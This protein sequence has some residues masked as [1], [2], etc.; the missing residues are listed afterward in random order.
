LVKVIEGLVSVKDL[1][2]DFGFNFLWGKSWKATKC[3]SGFLMQ[4]PSQERLDEMINFL[5]LKMKMSS[6][7]IV[8]VP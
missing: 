2:K 3:H 5:E 8:V 6:A 1:E 7:K 4:F